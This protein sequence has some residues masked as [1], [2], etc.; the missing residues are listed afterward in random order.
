MNFLAHIYLSGENDDLKF[1]NFIGD[2]VKGNKYQTYSKEVQKGILLHRKI[3]SYT[4]IHPVVKES[5]YRMRPAYGKYA[6][7]VIDILYDHYLAK[8]WGNYSSIKLEDYV[9]TFHD[10]IKERFNCLPHKS[11]RFAD[12]FIKKKR[13]LCYRNLVC[14]EDVLNKMAIYTSM[15]DNTKQ[16]MPIIN[17]SYDLFYKEFQ[18]FILDIKKY[19]KSTELN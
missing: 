11:K 7:V 15:P 8:N 19:L 16:A 1:G 18:F 17:K 10:L 12:P 2:W 9:N 14:F 3:D 4:D 13:L 5:I 6:G